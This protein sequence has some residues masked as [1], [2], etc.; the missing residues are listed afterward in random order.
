MGVKFKK[1][2]AARI[3]EMENGNLILYYE[4]MDKGGVQKAQ[5]DLVVLTVGIQ[6]NDEAGKFFKNATLQLD[7][8]G[9]I[10]EE[11]AFC[12]PATTSIRGVFAAG[13]AVEGADIPD[14]V[15]HSGA[16]AAQAS[17]YMEKRRQKPRLMAESR[18][19][20]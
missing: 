4:D 19:E 10:N 17:A 12:E 11:D 8:H 7:A 9:Y 14:T 20:R 2:K 16:A 18:S 15:I 1:A 3:D 6:A 5:H 13:T